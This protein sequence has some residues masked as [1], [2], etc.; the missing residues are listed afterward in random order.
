MADARHIADV[1]ELE[2]L[3]LGALKDIIEHPTSTTGADHGTDQG[4]D[5]PS[6][7]PRPLD[8]RHVP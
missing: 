3:T 4:T 1:G 8:E 7:H 5:Q 2:R 6:A